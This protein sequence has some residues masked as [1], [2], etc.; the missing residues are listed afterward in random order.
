MAAEECGQLFTGGA[1]PLPARKL[2][3]RGALCGDSPPALCGWLTTGLASSVGPEPF[4]MQAP[5][6]GVHAEAESPA[7]FSAAAPG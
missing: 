7:P 4:R 3:A 1:P 5:C 6:L 2:G